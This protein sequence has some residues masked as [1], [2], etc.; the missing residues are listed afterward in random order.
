MFEKI[1][2]VKLRRPETNIH[3]F[4][5][6]QRY[7]RACQLIVGRYRKTKTSREEFKTAMAAR[8]FANNS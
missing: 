7:R 2:G 8:W 3:Q 6:S 5:L 4:H 1:S